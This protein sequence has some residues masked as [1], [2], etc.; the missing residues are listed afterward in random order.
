MRITR[1]RP[2][3]HVRLERRRIDA[4][5]ETVGA[6]QAEEIICRAL[7]EVAVRVTLLERAYAAADTGALVKGARSLVA[8]ADQVGLEHLA[9][10]AGD[11][12]ACAGRGD[13]PALAAT[14][15]RLLRISDRSLTA[16]W[17]A[18]DLSG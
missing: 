9:H 11:V 6:A 14:L 2:D 3:E 15:G 8:I 1:I 13:G 5:Y 12:A 16:I 4:L 18:G 7:E 17:D 10:V